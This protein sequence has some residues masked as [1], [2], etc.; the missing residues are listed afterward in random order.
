[1]KTS[2]DPL[3]GFETR[4]LGEL[5]TVVADRADSGSAQQPQQSRQ[6]RLRRVALVAASVAAL[7][8]GGA[9][10][11]PRLLA[12]PAFAIETA[13]DG[14]TVITINRLEDAAGLEDALADHGIE[15]DVTYGG[16]APET[17]SVT[18]GDPPPEGAPAPP[19]VPEGAEPKVTDPEGH[20]TK[21]PK[22]VPGPEILDSP[23][24]GD[25]FLKACGLDPDGEPP[26]SVE[27][28]GDGYVVTI[29]AESIV[30][31][32]DLQLTTYADSEQSDAALMATWSGRDGTVCGA[33]NT[34]DAVQPPA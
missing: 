27:Q 10:V 16:A 24:D 18:E 11:A 34:T 6:P 7:A 9:V 8:V 23:A 14:D 12:S 26:I 4:L 22:G 1:M 25:P 20:A 29:P 15:A 13:A 3:D 17:Y 5:R 21:L 19:P 32:T 30:R 28:R 33:G 31:E 2:N